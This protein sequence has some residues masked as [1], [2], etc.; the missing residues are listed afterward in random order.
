MNFLEETTSLGFIER[1]YERIHESQKLPI[2][3]KG[4][5]EYFISTLKL[6]EDTI[7]KTEV[8]KFCNDNLREIMILYNRFVNKLIINPEPNF[9]ID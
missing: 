4:Y 9:A 8:L 2:D 7:L 3:I 6:I 1:Y 5:K